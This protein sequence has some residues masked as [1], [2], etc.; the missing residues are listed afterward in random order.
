MEGRA[1]VGVPGR[2]EA[3]EAD[4]IDA[5][6]RGEPP[7]AERVAFDAAFSFAAPPQQD[8]VRPRPGARSRPS[9][10]RSNA[11]RRGPTCS[12]TGASGLRFAAG[13][14][15]LTLAVG[16][17][18]LVMENAGMRSRIAS[19]EI[20]GRALQARHGAAEQQLSAEKAAPA[21]CPQLK[22]ASSAGVRTRDCLFGSAPG[23]TRAETSHVRL[24]IP[25]SAPLARIEFNSG[26]DAYPRCAN[27]T[28]DGQEVLTRGNLPQRRTAAGPSVSLRCPSQRASAG[29]WL[30]LR[31]ISAD[32]PRKRS[33]TTTSACSS[34]SQRALKSDGFRARNQA[35]TGSAGGGVW[36]AHDLRGYA[37]AEAWQAPA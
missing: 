7:R 8:R 29:D 17:G 13:L 34:L 26:Q 28:L 35:L 9:R 20:P 14:A 18:W 21:A 6:V 3:A 4:L 30:E 12:P 36:A 11:H 23:L 5:Y 10:R 32:K 37:L 19:L 25:P 33:V 16:L 31:G 1:P 27:C 22:T 24:V 2:G 15:T